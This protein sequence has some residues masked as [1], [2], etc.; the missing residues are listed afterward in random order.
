MKKDLVNKGKDKSEEKEIS[1]SKTENGQKGENENQPDARK[2]E[3]E[4]QRFCFWLCM[5]TMF[6]GKDFETLQEKFFIDDEEMLELCQIKTMQDF[7]IKYNVHNDTLT[8]WKRKAKQTDLFKYVQ[9]WAKTVNKN[10]VASAY[11]SAMSKDPKAHQDRKLMLQLGG[12]SEEQTVNVKGEGLFDIL[13]K[14]LNIQ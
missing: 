11:R 6:K 3:F 2:K 13:K 4:F 12:W 14:G 7:A 5:P 1:P 10:V 8:D 9:D